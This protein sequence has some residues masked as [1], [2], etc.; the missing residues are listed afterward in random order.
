MFNSSQ[1][2]FE[3]TNPSGGVSMSSVTKR[4]LAALMF[5]LLIWI[6]CGETYR[7]TIIPNAVPTPNPK[8]FHSAFAVNANGFVTPLQ[9]QNL[10][11]A[12]VT[13]GSGLQVDVSGDSNAGVNTVG[14]GPV[15]AALQMPN[16]NRLWVANTISDSVSVFNIANP[17][18][19]IGPVTTV[20][21]TTGSAPVFVHSTESSRMYV[22]N[23][24]NATVSVINTTSNLQVATI[25]VGTTPVALAETPDARKLYVVNRDSNNVTSINPVDQTP[26]STIPVGASPQW[27]VARNDSAR[28]YVL[29]TG[30]G[31]ITTIDPL[32]DAVLSTVP[33]SAGA[34]FVYYDGRLNRLYVPN[35]NGKVG[36]FDASV[37]PPTSLATID[38]TAPI[39][40]ATTTPCPSTGCSAVSVAALPDGTRAYIASFYLDSNSANC[41][42]IIGQVAVPCVQVQVTALNAL[43]NQVT[44]AISLPAVPVSSVGNCA[45]ARFRISAAPAADSTRVYIAGCDSGDVSIIDANANK[46]LVNLPAPVS[47]FPPVQFCTPG[48]DCS[49]P[50]AQP[51]TCN[52][53][54]Q[55]ASPV[56]PRQNSLFFLPGS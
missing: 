44:A 1:S 16:S 38:L 31:T 5:S 51:C 46:L 12:C 2:L 23:S 48:Q 13:P 9:C 21:L 32:T 41:S 19:H 20:N 50:T 39:P 27:A 33:V 49:C 56:P 45:A 53:G 24:G 28:V 26:N 11:T 47:S 55:C 8:N 30:A 35:P 6:A 17:V 36:I 18:A 7:P 25:A 52:A 37:D 22:A 4:R 40:G 3:D 54:Q 15:H 10:T 14:I 42:Q 34:T 29:S 43:T